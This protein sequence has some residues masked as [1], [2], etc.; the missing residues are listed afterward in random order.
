MLNLDKLLETINANIYW[1]DKEGRY[2]GCNKQMADFL[3]L[4]ETDIVGFTDKDL[5][6]KKYADKIIK[7]DNIVMESKET[8]I[9]HEIVNNSWGSI[10]R[11]LSSK[12]PLFDNHGNIAGV[13]G[14]SIDI[15]LQ[16][17]LDKRLKQ[18]EKEKGQYIDIKERFLRNIQHEISNP[19]CSILPVLSVL[20]EKWDFLKDAD[21]KEMIN[22]ACNNAN[23]LHRYIENTLN[24]S[25]FVKN[26]KLK[27][28]LE[29]CNLSQLLKEESA[30]LATFYELDIK[31]KTDQT[32]NVNIDKEKIGYLFDNII[33]NAKQWGK[34]Q[35]IN[36]E[37]S[38][39]IQ[40]EVPCV[41]CLIKDNGT[42]VDKEDLEI[43]FDPFT[44]STKTLSKACGKG[45]GLSVAKAI[46]ESHMGKI[47][48]EHNLT[49]AAIVFTLPLMVNHD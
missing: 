29:I 22:N 39:I 24:I 45:L 10:K 35:E 21:K 43:I 20:K 7:I 15:T 49:G 14:V 32:F 28:N 23:S 34:S 19:L 12:N 42:G 25:E 5:P 40:N 18:A 37:L 2:L 38:K 13:I 11:F 17:N 33:L 46:T 31:L 48:A 16:H 44:E 41:K 27:I 6:W 4:K 47:W 30:K 26:N 1:K 36:I 8:Y 9:L 3:N